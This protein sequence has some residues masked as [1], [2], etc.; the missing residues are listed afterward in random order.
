MAGYDYPVYTVQASFQ[1]LPLLC[2]CVC[3]CV[4][5]CMSVHAFLD[6][7]MYM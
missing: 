3:V 6:T 1:A 2:V 4:C 7:Y 5:V